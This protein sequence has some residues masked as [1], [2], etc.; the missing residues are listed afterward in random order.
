[1]F[2][3]QAW[4][5]RVWML[6]VKQL[7]S[8]QL[9]WKDSRDLRGASALCGT[10]NAHKTF[11]M[12]RW[13]AADNSSE[14]EMPMH[15]WTS[16]VST[17]RWCF[18]PCRQAILFITH[19]LLF[20][21]GKR[22]A[23]YCGEYISKY[24]ESP[25]T[26]HFMDQQEA[27]ILKWVESCS[28]GVGTRSTPASARGRNGP[29]CTSSLSSSSYKNLRRLL[30]HAV[31]LGSQFPWGCPQRAVRGMYVLTIRARVTKNIQR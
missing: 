5:W 29:E 1:M 19:V 12:A 2:L 9:W 6:L 16:S 13:A 20:N 17:P 28:A 8:W 22:R 25:E 14:G 15:A 31:C 18:P 3:G 7:L 27:Q 24:E 23:P 21:S 4:V 11:L 30:R 10:N 26:G